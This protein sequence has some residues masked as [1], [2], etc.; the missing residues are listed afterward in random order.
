MATS[1]NKYSCLHPASYRGTLP[2][3]HGLTTNGHTIF[4]LDAEN[5]GDK[6]LLIFL[7]FSPLEAAMLS[8]LESSENRFGKGYIRITK[9][10]STQFSLSLSLSLSLSPSSL[11][12]HTITKVVEVFHHDLLEN[13]QVSN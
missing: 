3:I 9:L 1:A 10:I 4:N 7:H 2:L 8:A 5:E 13:I 12:Y 11:A 6:V